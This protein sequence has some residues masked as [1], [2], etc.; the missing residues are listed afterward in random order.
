MTI[1]E[2]IPD[3]F[4]T[5]LEVWLHSVR[6]THQFLAEDDTRTPRAPRRLE[7]RE[8]VG[9]T[10]IEGMS[11]GLDGHLYALANSMEWWLDAILVRVDSVTGAGTQV[12]V[13][14]IPG[15]RDALY[16][17]SFP[18]VLIDVKPGSYPSCFN[19]NGAGVV[20]VAVLGN[21]TFDVGIIDPGT[22]VFGGMPVRIKGKN[23][24]QCGYED[25]N[26][27]G[28]MDLVCQFVDDP[29][30]WSPGDGYATLTGYLYSGAAFMGSDEICVTQ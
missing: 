18:E 24:P 2:A 19:I 4:E 28:W 8:R 9:F 6:A 3:D 27:D 15:P 23:T 14:D 26:F 17:V 21:E 29:L 12:Q 16:A 13:L 22:L 10:G 5:L 1:R 7:R 11:L 25:T 20:P 30:L